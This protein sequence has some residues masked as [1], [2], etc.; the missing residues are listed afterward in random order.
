MVTK[1]ASSSDTQERKKK[2]YSG[3]ILNN[4]MTVKEETC[5]HFCILCMF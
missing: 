1:A 4:E 5:V 3:N 2:E